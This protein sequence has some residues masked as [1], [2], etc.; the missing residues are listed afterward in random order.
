MPGCVL[1]RLEEGRGIAKLGEVHDH[2]V[3]VEA[4]SDQTA[5]AKA[6]D[7]SREALIKAEFAA[8]ERAGQLG[9]AAR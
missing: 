8:H 9:P 4:F 3:R 2:E 1:M 5:V 6:E 7:L